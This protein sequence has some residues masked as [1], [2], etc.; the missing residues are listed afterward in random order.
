MSLDDLARLAREQGAGYP[1]LMLDLAALDQNTKVVVDFARAQGWG[2]RPALKSFRSPAL[3]SYLLNR[4]PQPRGLVF[5]LSEVDPIVAAA[6]RGADLMTG[7]PPTFGELA[8]YLGAKPPRGL[9]KHRLRILVDSVPLMEHLARLAK[10]TRRRVPVDVALEL[11][12][13]MGRGGINDRAELAACLDV[14]RSDRQRLRLTGV[15]GYDGHATL[16]GDSEY[17]QLVA[18]QAQDSYRTHLANL[19][20]LGAGLYDERTLIRNGPGSSNYRNWVGGPADE[21]GCGSAFLFAGYLNGGYDTDGLAP[22]LSLGGAVRRITSD[23]PSVPVLGITQPGAS[24]MEIIVQG[25]GSAGEV[26][27]PPGARGD[28]ASGGGDAL[29]VPKGSVAL[30]DYVIYRPE[31]AEVGILR[32][33]EMLAVR[34]GKVLRRWPVFDRP[35]AQRSA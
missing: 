16:R 22:A 13:G 28:D 14:L 12:V 21:I 20:A 33:H 6:P 17:R 9:R 19:A 1:V 34:E 3:I 26:A 15:L 8:A 31:Q 35:G 29:I 7:Y 24:E 23:H 18:A 5:N 25:V 27:H 4:L 2:V 32:F 10:T 30:G 11:D